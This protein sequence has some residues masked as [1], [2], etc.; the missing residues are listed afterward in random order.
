[1][2]LLTKEDWNQSAS[3]RDGISPQ[4]ECKIR[5]QMLNL[6][7]EVERELNHTEKAYYN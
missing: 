1:M 5:Y 7:R 3:I 2:K 4:T 6:A